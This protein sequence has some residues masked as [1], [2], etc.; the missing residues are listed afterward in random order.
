LI[1]AFGKVVKG[2][3]AR[4]IR[5]G[6]FLRDVEADN[7]YLPAGSKKADWEVELAVVIGKRALLSPERFSDWTLTSAG[8]PR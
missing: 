5:Q 4:D 7:I 3:K 8:P 6:V 1:L 2:A